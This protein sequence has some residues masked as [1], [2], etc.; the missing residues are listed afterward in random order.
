MPRGPNVYK[1]KI[2][3]LHKLVHQGQ[4]NGIPVKKTLKKYKVTDRAYYT[5]CKQNNLPSWSSKNKDTI[6]TK[7]TPKNNTN[8]AGGH[9][10]SQ[11]DNLFDPKK[12]GVKFKEQLAEIKSRTLDNKKKSRELDIKLNGR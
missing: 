6:L 3:E 9:L 5:R 10:E 1:M 11:E 2:Q 8:L 7:K 12:N 4:D